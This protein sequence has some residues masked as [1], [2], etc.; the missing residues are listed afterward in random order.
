M[1]RPIAALAISTLPMTNSLGCGSLMLW[2]TSL[3]RGSTIRAATVWLMKVATTKIRPAK[4]T[5]TLYR[6]NPS[7]LSVMLPA[8]VCKRPD[9]L[10]AFPRERPPAARII[11]VQRKLLK[12]SL[13]K[14]PV[15]KKR[16]S[17]RMATTP[18]SPKTG[19]SWWLTHQSPMVTTVTALMNH[20]V[21]VNLSFNGR[22]G[23][24]VV[25]RPGLK[26]TRSR[27]QMRRIDI[28]QTGRAMKNHSPH[29]GSG[30][31][32]SSAIRFCGDAIGDAA[33]PMLEDRAM[34]SKRAFVMSDSAGRLR[35]MGCTLLVMTPGE[36][37]ELNLLE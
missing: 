11:M 31:M 23:T 5:R 1:G 13:V 10:T 29:E 4:T 30:N 8:I 18:I 22:M 17:G 27:T 9:E 33:P 3:T 32:F 19:S 6:L 12:S 28:M 21:L 14:M 20:C 25:L 26:V 15:P 36:H 24:I 7:T 16:T 37:A 2:P 35:R 34:P